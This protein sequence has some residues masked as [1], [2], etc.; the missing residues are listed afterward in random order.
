MVS[1]GQLPDIFEEYA[2]ES[3]IATE[4]RRIYHNM[5]GTGEGKKYKSFLVTSS[6]QGEGK[7]TV[8]S[9]LA[10]TIAQYPK[11][12]VLI[13]DADVRRPKIHKFFKADNTVGLKECLSDEADPMEIVQSTRIPNLD[14]I[15]AGGQCDEPSRLF[16]RDTLSGFFD[17]IGFYYDVV[18]VDSGPVL[19]VSDTLFLCSVVEAVLFVLL[20]GITPREV[21]G[22][23]MEALKDSGANVLGV[24]VNNATDTLPYHYGYR[25]YKYD[26]RE[27]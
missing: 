18:L 22:R 25:Y 23:A 26:K 10:L 8:I 13:V 17:K 19:A 11:L 27:A 14:L 16:E 5:R 3:P 6:T 7:S 15:T 2:S 9:Y 21:A 1:R 12:K 20:A 24:V 4:L